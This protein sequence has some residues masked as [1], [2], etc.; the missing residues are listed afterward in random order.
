MQSSLNLCV[1]N[2]MF[3]FDLLCN[4]FIGVIQLIFSNTDPLIII[5]PY[6]IF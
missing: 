6:G 1:T 5:V 2:K 3:L 4:L